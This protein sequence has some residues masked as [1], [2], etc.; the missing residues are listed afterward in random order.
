[1]P[2]GGR[3]TSPVPQ[4][5]TGAPVRARPRLHWPCRAG[6]RRPGRRARGK[7]GPAG[8]SGRA[9]LV[10]A[11]PFSFCH[12]NPVKNGPVGM[13]KAGLLR[14]LAGPTGAACLRRV[15][16]GRVGVRICIRGGLGLGLGGRFVGE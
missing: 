3:S 13:T 9:S 5:R 7:G 10:P 1:R 4:P 2:D 15:V 8:S 11:P 14:G 16:A 6:P 12:P